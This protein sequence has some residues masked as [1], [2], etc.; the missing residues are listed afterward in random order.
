[1]FEWDDAKRRA[2]LNK[3]GIDFIDA[4]VIF[5]S[6]QTYSYPSPKNDED[7]WVTVG[8]VKGRMIAVIWTERSEAV[9]IMSARRARD[10]EARKHCQLF[11]G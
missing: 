5:A 2:N 6:E 1:V 3:H 8:V 10:E 9:R 11:G 7:R 4:Q